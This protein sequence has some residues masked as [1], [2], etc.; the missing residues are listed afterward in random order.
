MNG[1]RVES[2]AA[3]L[4]PTLGLVGQRLV[5][6]SI[7]TSAA[8]CVLALSLAGL[9]VVQGGGWPLL[10]LSLLVA[11]AAGA[12]MVQ[13]AR[14]A[15]N[16]SGLTATLEELAAGDATAR[17]NG[18]ITAGNKDLAIAIDALRRR[19][20]R[21]VVG[22]R[23]ATSTLESAWREMSD[24]SVAMSDNAET[25]AARA[26]DAAFSAETLSAAVQ[27][28]AAATQ[29]LVMSFQ[30]VAT[31]ASWVAQVASDATAKVSS[32]KAT[33][34][35]LAEASGRAEQIVQVITAV[36]RQTHL[37]ALN[38][39][40]EAASAGEHGAAFSVIADEVK[41]LAGMTAEGAVDVGTTVRT[42]QAGS[43]EVTGGMAMLDVTI[44]SLSDAQAA[45]AAAVEE[46]TLTTRTIG[47][48]ATEAA[49]GT[50]LIA[51]TIAQF[52][53]D[54]GLT[55]YAGTQTR[56]A[57]GNIASA[58]ANLMAILEGFMVGDDDPE[59]VEGADAAEPKHV[60]TRDGDVTVITNDVHG[61]GLHELLYTGA[62]SHDEGSAVTDANSYSSVM[63]D[64]V[65]MQFSGSCVR[66]FGVK[67][68]HHGILGVSIDGAAEVPADT[69]GAER[70][71]SALIY[72]RYDLAGRDH[73]LR[74]RI[75][76]E[77]N[78]ASRFHWG[79]ITRIEV[80]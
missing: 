19:M 68:A 12:A 37:L 50:S 7:A 36:A 31:Q 8:A 55:A 45:I 49:D 41:H 39:R 78:A 79:A 25:T 18:P 56:A 33:A 35:S 24:V 17:Y 63:G 48:G 80:Q 46:Q 23:R 43:T 60:A 72:E 6:K 65:H 9:L 29:E 21:T 34:A 38:A 58:S 47:Q 61:S 14:D 20:H 3:R 73:S 4:R 2:P 71:V 30:E 59:E 52:A 64:S 28:V 54:A 76:G 22:V 67:D 5:R 16:I 15:V 51:Q 13:Q 11:V 70:E 57:A 74:L 77:R 10:A 53:K 62:W 26:T 44:A 32:T 69:Y 42:I 27:M 1:P 75:T 66:V 40:I